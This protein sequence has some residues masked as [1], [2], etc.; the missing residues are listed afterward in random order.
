M[1][2]LGLEFSET[3]VPL[4]TPEF[5]DQVDAIS[6][7]GKVPVLTDG[8][9]IVWD[10]LA[11]AEYLAERCPGAGVWPADGAA[12]AHARCAS[13]EMHSGFSALRSACPMNLGKKFSTKDRGEGV[14][15]D[16]ARIAALWA[17]GRARF[18]AKS[19]QPFLYGAFCAA[20]AMFAPV[21]T[22]L[23][24][25]SIEVDAPTRAYMEAVLAHPA[26]LEWKAAGLAETWIVEHDEVDEPAIATYR[27]L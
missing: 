16:V 12:R 9:L 22:R 7:A 4:D 20:D 15:K 13:A 14:A 23:D 21:V 8:D 1:R 2:A 10:S 11:I 18:G 5:R 17:D 19:D 26:F 6:G 24:T 27:N 3:V 25:Y